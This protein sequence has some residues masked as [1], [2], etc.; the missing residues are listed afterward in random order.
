MA[1]NT[2][3]SDNFIAKQ[4]FCTID[5]L[6]KKIYRY[7]PNV[8]CDISYEDSSNRYWFLKPLASIFAGTHAEWE[9][10]NMLN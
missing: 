4:T 9:D 1:F 2:T 10:Q 7:F 6:D 3:S 8:W 5:E